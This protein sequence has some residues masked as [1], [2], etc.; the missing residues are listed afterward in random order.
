M[1]HEGPTNGS[2]ELASGDV[3]R[4][5]VESSGD[6]ETFSKADPVSAGDTVSLIFRSDEEA[7]PPFTLRIKSPAGKVILERV[8]REL[9]TGRPQ[10][11]PPIQF[12]ASAA[13]DYRIEIWQLYGKSRGDAILHVQ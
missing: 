5:V 2:S 1:P 8:L 13:G 12:T 7:N 10:S 6:I 4:P 3:A 11:A 9:P